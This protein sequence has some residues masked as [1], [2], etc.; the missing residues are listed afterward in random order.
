MNLFFSICSNNYLAQATVLG[1][2]LKMYHPETNFFLFLCDRKIPGI[3]YSA[4]ADEVIEM[5]HIEPNFLG[6]VAK[7][8]IIELN[9]CVKPRVFE[10]LLLEKEYDQ[11]IFLDPD[12][13]I[14]HP[15][16]GLFS[17][18]Q[19]ENIL[20]TP[21]IYSPIPIDGKKP[22][23]ENFLIYGIYNLGFISILRT[24]E[25]F[26]F[27]R[28]WKDRTY[29]R[30]Y[31]DTY[32]GIFVDQLPLN[33][34]PVFFENVYILKDF[35]IN[36]APWNL[37]ERYLQYHEEGIFVNGTTRLKFYHFSSFE[38]NSF[39]ELPKNNNTRFKMEVRPD[40][41][42]IYNLYNEELLSVGHL[43]YRALKN[44]YGLPDNKKRELKGFSIKFLFVKL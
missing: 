7:Y 16:T 42:P 40:L 29:Q 21:H 32:N 5:E 34:A 14:F 25:S 36:M 33:L 9:T 12:V 3:N 19:N 15:L 20:L 24:E 28:W 38:A 17:R 23:E 10:Y 18:F 13:R 22:G 37:H 31:I 4:I 30:G 43:E 8:N 44:A 26:K 1:R 39:P 35:G 27:V 6:L 41:A 2:S 11:V